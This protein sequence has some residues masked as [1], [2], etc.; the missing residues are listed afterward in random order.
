MERPPSE[1]KLQAGSPEMPAPFGRYWL[2]GL[3]ARGGMAEVYRARDG[4]DPDSPIIAIKIM[5]PSLAREAKF[6][7]MFNRESKLAKLLKHPC[8]VNT[9]DAGRCEG[10]HYLALE[11]LGGCDL[12][13]L[14]KRCQQT[15]QRVPVPHALYIAARLAESLA[16]A[17]TLAD[18]EGR[19]LQIVN[20]DISPAN[21]RISYDGQVKLLDFG[22]AQAQT[23]FTTEIG[24]LKGKYSYM[25]PEQIRGMPL[26]ARSDV[27][28]LGIVL[29]ELLTTE[30]L[31]RGDTEFG[32]M[33][34]VRKAEVTAPSAL[35]RRVPPDVD[36]I[37]LRALARDVD[38]R[39]QT[40]AELQQDLD[41]AT[42]PFQFEPRELRQFVRQLFRKELAIEEEVMSA[43]A[44]YKLP[45]ASQTIAVSRTTSTIP[46]SAGSLANASEISDAVNTVRL[47]ALAREKIDPASTPPEGMKAATRSNQDSTQPRT[48][49]PPPIG[50]APQAGVGTAPSSTTPPPHADKPPKKWWER[51]IG[52]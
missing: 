11:Y 50:A 1:T 7:D 47:R 9:V 40:A 48:T 41:A 15:D 14:L 20:R 18:A 12:S 44:A 23:R 16:F 42:K 49:L 52:R 5:R 25:S 33:E 43:I 27:F 21:V 29:H 3:I 17:H 46:P 36:T 13:E 34:K 39:Y 4:K 6:V 38:A 26:D 10:R 22:I 51:I 30:K 37:V 32:L 35:N 45:D 2:F 28:S 24:T 31:F 8:I 19:P